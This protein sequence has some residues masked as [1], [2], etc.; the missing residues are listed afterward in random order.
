MFISHFLRMLYGA[1][2]GGWLV[3]RNVS[4]EGEPVPFVW[5]RRSFS[6]VMGIFLLFSDSCPARTH[7]VPPPLGDRTLSKSSF[8]GQ[9]EGLIKTSLLYIVQLCLS[10]Q[11]RSTPT[12][13]FGLLDCGKRP[14]AG[15]I[16]SGTVIGLHWTLIVTP[17]GEVLWGLIKTMLNCYH[18]VEENLLMEMCS[19]LPK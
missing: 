10:G 1:G 2:V 6:L 13:P 3:D 18:E 11:R 19:I 17:E 7:G 9:K 4:G 8:G 5:R 15:C 16:S 14:H 12:P